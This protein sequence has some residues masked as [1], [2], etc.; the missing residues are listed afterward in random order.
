MNTGAN[1]SGVKQTDYMK[2]SFNILT[3]IDRMPSLCNNG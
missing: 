1:M 3:N 2:G